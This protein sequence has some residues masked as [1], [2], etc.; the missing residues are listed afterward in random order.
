MV[1]KKRTALK[2]SPRER[3]AV[4]E[5]LAKVRQAYSEKIQRVALFGSKARGDAT[6][7]SDI[8]IL[9]IVSDDRWN[10]RQAFSVIISDIALK[11]D[12]LLDVRV[13]SAAR[14]QYLA[15]IQAGLYQNIS[16]DAVALRFHKRITPA[17]R[18]E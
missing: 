13:I 3:K 14:W 2:L 7:Y 8:D 16:R 10:F 11:Y 5:F 6:Q 15:E 17:A 4:Q 12:V 18:A 1:T 9:L